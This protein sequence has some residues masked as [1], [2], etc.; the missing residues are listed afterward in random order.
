MLLKELS[1][2]VTIAE[3]DER[4]IVIEASFKLKLRQK[5]KELLIEEELAR[6]K[7]VPNRDGHH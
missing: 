4:F 7:Y 6:R 5:T 3:D 1:L 2:P